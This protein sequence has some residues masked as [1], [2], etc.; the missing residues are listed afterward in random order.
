M[1]RDPLE[2]LKCHIIMELQ[3]G[4]TVVEASI[5]N[6]IF[7]IDLHRENSV[8]GFITITVRDIEIAVSEHYAHRHTKRQTDRQTHKCISILVG[9]R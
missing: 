9:V 8:I 7:H 4:L 3:L 2:I 5:V 1:S 6:F